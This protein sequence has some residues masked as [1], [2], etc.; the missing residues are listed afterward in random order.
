MRGDGLSWAFRAY[1][2]LVVFSLAGS[3]LSRLSGLDP[4]WIRPVAG[5]LTLGFG[6]WAVYAPYAASVGPVEARRALAL[7][8]VIGAGSEIV[9][10]YT[11]LPFGRYEYT[12]AWWPAIPLPGGKVFPMLLPFAWMMMAGGAYLLVQRK[13][14]GW[15]AAVMGGV[16]AALADLPMEPVMAG[17][18]GYWKWLEQGPLPGGAPVMNFV[19]WVLTAAAAGAILAWRQK[20]ERVDCPEPGLVLAVHV[21]FTVLLGLIL[22]L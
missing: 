9:G 17:P 19:G 16:V 1:V 20:G 15:M 10:L 22:G 2:G 6:F 4:G 3:L 7:V 21:A 11:G 13:V 14:Y 5:A 8:F 18:L 12:S